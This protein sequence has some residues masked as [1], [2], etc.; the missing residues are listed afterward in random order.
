MYRCLI[1][2]DELPAR[3]ELL[4]ILKDMKGVEV[5]GEATHGMEALELVESLKPDIIFLDIQMPQMSGIEVAKSLL[6]KKENKPIVIFVTAY[7]Q[8][9]LEAF[10]V[11]AVDYLL[12]PIREERL[13]KRLKEIISRKKEDPENH[14]LDKLIEYMEI[15]IKATP[16]RIS[17][18]QQNRLVPIEMRDIIYITI[19]DR[20]TTIY[21]IRGRFETNHT[22]N[23]LMEKLD[24][25]T[26]FR[27]HKSY[28][29]NLDYIEFI[30]PW[31]NST[32]NI[33]LKGSKTV[34]PV[35]RNY[36]KEFRKLMNI[37]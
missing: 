9:A 8:F 19:E 32:Y 13:E 14:R 36:G 10:E 3:Q 2:D 22:L 37:E 1:V 15:N 4:Y 30:E 11:N 16:Q 31:F 17:L 35:S 21:S 34:I 5:V 20:N 18:Y 23:E 25:T 24:A 26:F 27:S 12:K 29:V 28:I 33:Y 6:T 7:D